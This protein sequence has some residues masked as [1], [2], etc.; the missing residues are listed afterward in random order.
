MDYMK[1]LIAAIDVPLACIFLAA[2][3][4]LSILT[5]FPQ[6]KNLKEFIKI[7][8]LKKSHE[9]TQG[10]ISPLHALY[11]AMSTTLGMGNIV[12]PAVAIALGGPGALFWM[13]IYAIFG[14]V[15]KYVEVFFAVKYKRYAKDGSIIGGPT[16]YLYQIHPIIANWYGIV[17]IFLFSAWSA[18]QSKTIATIY[19]HYH[20]EEYITGTLLALFILGMLL[21]GT[22][23]IGKFAARIVPLLFIFYASTAIIILG[24]NMDLLREAILS[25]F[26]SAFAPTAPIGGFIGSTMLFGLRQGIFKGAFTTEAGIGTAAIAHSYAATDN[27]KQQAIL[28]MYSIFINNFLCIVS[29]LIALVTGVWKLGSVSNDLALKAFTLAMPTF[30][31]IILTA[32][33]S[34]CIIGATLGN[35]FNGS[36]TFGFFT[37]NRFMNIYYIFVAGLIFTG[38]II[39][40]QT[41]WQITDLLLPLI[42][43]P[44]LLGIMFLTVRNRKELAS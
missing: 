21:N 18:L 12:S 5:N 1:T 34:I 37:N 33:I 25:I 32:T 41:L 9:S 15:T 19:A 11:L 27:P 31:P 42:V 35:S 26:Q 39:D 14:S 17:S 36:K 16:G 8:N 20:V 44:N 29:G 30:G 40:T 43:I 2:G 22:K 10:T 4:L 28:G 3:I 6:L 23:A 7:L 38:A 24:S 13:S